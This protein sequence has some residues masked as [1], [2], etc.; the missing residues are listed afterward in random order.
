[1]YTGLWRPLGLGD[2]SRVVLTSRS[3]MF[4]PG[5]TDLN[6][7]NLEHLRREQRTLS[8]V[9]SW[10]AYG[11]VL[12]GLGTA[13]LVDFEFVTGA[14]ETRSRD[15]NATLNSL[16]AHARWPM[17]RGF[18]SRAAIMNATRCQILAGLISSLTGNRRRQEPLSS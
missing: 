3:N 11:S 16:G 5:L 9:D 13:E 10:V 1:M 15:S 18:K 8:S 2:E 7:A 6:W 12:A 17:S 4:R 14:L